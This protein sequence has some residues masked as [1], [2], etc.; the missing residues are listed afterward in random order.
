[1]LTIRRIKQSLYLQTIDTL[2]LRLGLYLE[3]LIANKQQN[4]NC[5]K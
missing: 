2:K 5:S 3:T 1:M 4:R